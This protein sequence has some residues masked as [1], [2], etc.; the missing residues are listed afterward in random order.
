MGVVESAGQQR[1]RGV[2]DAEQESQERSKSTTMMWLSERVEVVVAAAVHGEANDNVG[3]K[4]PQREG[5]SS[6]CRSDRRTL[7][8]VR[9]Q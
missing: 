6:R 7:S 4:M 2:A 1:L 9:R 8:W 3:C 5:S